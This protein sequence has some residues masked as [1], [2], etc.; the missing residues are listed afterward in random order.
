MNRRGT[1]QSGRS[2]IEM[3]GVLAIISVLSVGGLA[4]YNVAMGKIL[5][6]VN[7]PEKNIRYL[8]KSFFFITKKI[9]RFWK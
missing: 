2:M 8:K 3:L 1:T 4:G 9:G 5:A 7:C 6:Q